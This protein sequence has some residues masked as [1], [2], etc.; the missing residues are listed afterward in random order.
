LIP[1]NDPAG[2]T[3]D[4]NLASV[5]SVAALSVGFDGAACSADPAATGVG[6]QHTFL[7]DLEIS[8]RSPSGSSVRL[9]QR[10]LAGF[11]DNAGNHLCQTVLED[12]ASLP[13]QEAAASAEPYTGNFHPAEALQ[14]FAG[15][16]AAGLW[17]LQI[18]DLAPGDLGV[19]RA[20]RLILRPA[21]CDPFAPN[22]LLEDG[23]E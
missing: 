17:Q 4:L 20:F 19:V 21:L 22:L 15:E 13:I 16:P 1:D 8:L 3:I 9:L 2:V 7:G 14:A 6:L 18:A 11:G 12:T 23:F 5:G 10:P